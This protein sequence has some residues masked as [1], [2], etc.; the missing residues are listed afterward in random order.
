M[1]R[2]RVGVGRRWRRQNR[3]MRFSKPPKHVVDDAAQLDVGPRS[4]G[5]RSKL[6]PNRRPVDARDASVLERRPDGAPRR[7]ERR[8]GERGIDSAL[9]RAGA[10]LGTRTWLIDGVEIRAR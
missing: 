9:E 3:E 4:R 7:V 5:P 10:G 8:D 2:Q 6:T 1:V